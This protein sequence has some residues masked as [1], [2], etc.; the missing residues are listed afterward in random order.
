MGEIWVAMKSII[1]FDKK[2]LLIQRSKDAGGGE[3]DWEIPGGGIKFGEDLI[4]G[5]RR[6]INEEVGLSVRVEKL[7]YAMTAL[8]NPQRQIVGLTYLSHADDDKVT[9]SH[10]HIN[11]LWATKNQLLEMLTKHMMN[12]FMKYSVLDI[13]E[14]D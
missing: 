2:I 10:E 8:V 12:D 5:L 7:L 13:L 4:D 11:Y 6:E 14:I 9:L 3:G 1:L